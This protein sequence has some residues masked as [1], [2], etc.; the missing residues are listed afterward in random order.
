MGKGLV[1][2]VGAGTMGSGIAQVFAQAGYRVV[3]HDSL[4][5]QIEKARASV[6]ASL[7]RLEKAGKLGEQ[8]DA[9]LSRIE[10]SDSLAGLAEA[11]LVI[12]AVS[13]KKNLKQEI[14]AELGRLVGAN[15]ILASNTSSIS[16]TA[17]AGATRNPKRVVGIHFMNPA[18][19]MPLVEIVQGELTSLE[20]VE[21]AKQIVGSLGKTAVVSADRPGFIVNRMLIPMINEAIF[22][23][24]EGVA[25]RDDID[26]AM[27]LGARHPMGPLELADLIGLDICL[28][29]MET[30]YQEFADSKYRPCPLLRRMVEAG[31]LGRKTGRGFY[32]YVR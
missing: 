7:Q 23:L 15:A 14:F 10:D 21:K 17:L 1:G 5:G 32:E 27:K 22:A 29:V 20:T 18:P 25:T 28:D 19:V 24:M 13:E 4:P 12:E 2:V 30:L 11:T 16:I 26:Q 3:L 31:L 6:V 8:P 9:V